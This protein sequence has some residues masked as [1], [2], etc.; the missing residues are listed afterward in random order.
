MEVIFI[1]ILGIAL[2]GISFVRIPILGIEMTY[3]CIAVLLLYYFYEVIIKRRLSI[4]K[5]EWLLF[6]FIVWGVLR[7]ICSFFGISDGLVSEKLLI[8]RAFLPRHA[9]YLAFLPVVF[10]TNESSNKSTIYGFV[11]KYSRVLFWG[12]VVFNTIRN[13]GV[14]LWIP[15]LFILSFLSLLNEREGLKDWLMAM[16]I[17]CCPVFTGGELTNLLIRLVYVVLFLFRRKSK[18]VLYGMCLGIWCCVAMCFLLPLMLSHLETILDA[19]SLWRTRFWADELNMLVESHFMGV[20][21]GTSYAS[22][23]FLNPFTYQPWGEGDPFVATAQYSIYDKVFVTG[24]HNSF[25][26]VAF[27]LGLVGI[28]LFVAYLFILQMK[29][30]K[31]IQNISL[32]SLYLICSGLTIIALNVGL[33]SPCYLLMFVFAVY[34][35][36]YELKHY[37]GI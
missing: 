4:Q 25:V 29:Q 19:N 15:E 9:Y 27:R 6:T 11:K 17:V 24:P 33:E 14:G 37:V 7:A 18:F 10:L 21:F 5:H 8:D 30:L 28:G 1:T 3:I 32:G 26:S 2:F 36:S 16:V 13:K 12:I 35:S 20:G 31:H 22:S 34:C 23:N